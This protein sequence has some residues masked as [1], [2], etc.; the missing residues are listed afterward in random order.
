M[1]AHDARIGRECLQ[2]RP[3]DV[4]YDHRSDVHA[5]ERALETLPGARRR[6]IAEMVGDDQVLQGGD[7]RLQVDQE[8]RIG[9][10]AARRV[11]DRKLDDDERMTVA[12][13]DRI[14]GARIGQ[15]LGDER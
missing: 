2:F 3:R 9:A 7:P 5:L 10:E 6:R 13:E 8:G 14:E 15:L 1:D 12:I 4:E 11:R